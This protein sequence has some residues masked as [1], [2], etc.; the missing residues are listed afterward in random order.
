MADPKPHTP[1]E[2]ARISRKAAVSRDGSRV[3]EAVRLAAAAEPVDFPE[4][5]IGRDLSY[6]ARASNVGIRKTSPRSSWAPEAMPIEVAKG[7]SRGFRVV[8]PYQ[9]TGA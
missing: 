3:K 9:T 2:Q 5:E 1:Q 6:V 8:W 7:E 4:A